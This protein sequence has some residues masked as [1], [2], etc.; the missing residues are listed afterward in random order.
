MKNLILIRHAK[1][2]WD[3]PLI[4]KDRPLSKRGIKDAHLVAP[5]IENYLPETYIVW[6]STAQRTKNTAYIFAENLSIPQDTIVFK[7]SLYTFDER[8]LE[9]I[10]KSCDDQYDNLIIFGHN[11]AITNFVNTF[12]DRLVENVPTSGFVHLSFTESS[13]KEIEKG[14][15]EKLLFP[16][17][18]KQY[19]SSL[20]DKPLY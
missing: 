9:R 10:I 8:A 11:D 4:D 2:S 5:E 19:D 6:C 18:L 13:W 7:D 17:D 20:A 16:R 1:S 12:G 14:K 15:I 3:A